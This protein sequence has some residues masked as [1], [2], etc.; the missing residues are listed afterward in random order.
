M[1]AYKSSEQFIT[2]IKNRDL[3][4]IALYFENIP[5]NYIRTGLKQH[6]WRWDADRRCWF[7]YLTQQ[8]ETYALS[9]GAIDGT[10]AEENAMKDRQH[11][12][13][14][15]S[16]PQQFSKLLNDPALRSK[17]PKEIE[18]FLKRLD[19]PAPKALPSP[20]LTRGVTSAVLFSSSGKIIAVGITTERQNHDESKDILW[21]GQKSAQQ[22]LY[23]ILFSKPFVIYKGDICWI[24]SY[25]NTELIQDLFAHNKNFAD[26]EKMVPIWIQKL[27]QVCPAHPKSVE[28]VTAYVSV[29]QSGSRY[30][31]NVFYCPVCKKYYINQDQYQTFCKRFGLPDIMLRIDAQH[32]E[33]PD[34]GNWQE[35]SLLHF[36]GYNVSSSD[37]LSD[38]E[39]HRILCHAIKTGSMTKAEVISFLDFLV[40]QFRNR[41]SFQSSC[42][43]WRLDR[44]FISSYRAEDQ[45]KIVGRFSAPY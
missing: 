27:K 32:S 24:A 6:G 35:E 38:E 43:L 2:Y 25:S 21:I 31:I 36:M 39:R 16:I 44:D 10:A 1:C 5:S 22:I 40:H 14:A 28:C 13:Y 15:E 45:E 30:P 7:T 26:A 41:S 37:S 9:L 3:Q 4:E 33:M 29:S 19:G 34:Y 12:E 20:Y 11:K 17:T 8:A 42:A 23:G 18:T